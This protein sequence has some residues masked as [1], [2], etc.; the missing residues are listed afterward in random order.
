MESSYF[1]NL[2]RE[3]LQEPRYNAEMTRAKE[4][5]QGFAGQI[6]ETDHSYD[7]RINAFHNWYILD[8]PL[9]RTRLTPLES[10]LENNAKA[11]PPPLAASYAELGAN[12]HS[13]FE[14]VRSGGEKVQVRD[15]INGI[16]QTV[17]GTEQLKF[18]EKGALFNTR[19]FN[20]QGTLHFSNYYSLHPPVI[21]KRIRQEAHKVRKA[22]S[23]PKPF[24][25]Q[26]LLYQSRWDQYKQMTLKNIYRFDD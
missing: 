12:R 13:L 11:L 18:V 21:A 25:F 1:E 10:Y 23:N 24:L 17:T 4:E 2:L 7:A 9:S 19:L 6:F 5:F 15:L 22:R 16:R 26:L 3:V 14:M 8:R 20:H